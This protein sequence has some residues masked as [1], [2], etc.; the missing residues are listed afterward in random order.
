MLFQAIS[1]LTRGALHVSSNG[2]VLISINYGC[3]GIPLLPR[4]LFFQALELSIYLRF[5]KSF[6]E[7]RNQRWLTIP[8]RWASKLV[9]PRAKLRSAYE[10]C[11]FLPFYL[12]MFMHGISLPIHDKVWILFV[13]GEGQYLDG[14][15]W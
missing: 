8:R 7:I 13:S 4:V 11:L 12:W 10:F 5:P 6:K 1:S 15:S 9:R 2:L 14:Q 3:H